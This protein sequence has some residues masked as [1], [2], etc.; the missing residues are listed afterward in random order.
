MAK[1]LKLRRGTT[2]QHSSFTGAE[3]EV[4]VDTDKETLVVHNGSTAGGFALSRA[5]SPDNQKTR[6]GTGNDLEIYHDGSH[7]LVTNSTG[8]L[9]LMA[10]G[11]GVTIS[12]GDN[13]ETIAA[14]LKNG[15]VDL[16]YDNSKKFETTSTGVAISGSAKLYD[17]NK[18][19]CGHG[20]DLK[21]F[22]DG[23][24]SYIRNDTNQFYIM[25]QNNVYLQHHNAGSSIEDMLIAKGDGAVDLYYDNSKKFETHSAGCK[26]SAGNLYLDRDNAKLVLGASDD[27][28]IYH[29]GT[30]SYVRGG[31]G[32]LRIKS[33]SIKCVNDANDE[34]YISAVNGGAVELYHNNSKKFETTSSGAFCTGQL[35]V[36][37]LYMGDNDK[38]KF[39]NGDDLQIYHN[40]SHS[41][42]DNAVGSLYIRNTGTNWILLQPKTGETSVE[43]AAN[44]ATNLYYD[45]VKKLET[46]SSGVQINGDLLSNSNVKVYDNYSFLA[47][48]GNDLQIYHTGTHSYIKDAGAGNLYILTNQLEVMNAAGNAYMLR[49]IEGASIEL[50]E[51]GSKKLETVANGINVTGKIG[52]GDNTPTYEIEAKAAAPQI[53]LE[54]TSTGGSKRLDIRVNSS[55]QAYIGANQTAQSLIFQTTNNDRLEVKADGDIVQKSQAGANDTPGL[56]WNGGSSSQ[57]ANLVKLHAKQVSNWGGE[58][59]VK[60]KGANGSLSDNWQDAIRV[61]PEGSVTKPLQPSFSARHTSRHTYSHG[62]NNNSYNTEMWDV[63]SDYNTSNNRFTAPQ[64]GYYFLLHCITVR[65]GTSGILEAKIYINNSEV[66]RA[67][68]YYAG[69]STGCTV[70]CF[71]VRYLAANDY[72]TPHSH[73]SG[74][75]GA[76]QHW[77]NQAAKPIVFFQGHLCH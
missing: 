73:W 1:L 74:S 65:G 19:L 26:V 44:G 37:T 72:V 38:A 67:Y 77:E 59:M 2:S 51:N 20:D 52:I 8:Y 23:T 17:G 16:Y 45:N 58:F 53:R 28:Q 42:L 7:S 34:T 3:G 48:S 60:V 46:I 36:D 68:E 54:E 76:D 69:G 27:I 56:I 63:N 13:S 55:G 9:R 66:L 6:W 75:T 62:G 5:D 49:C 11:S 32:D 25:G 10:G 35:G 61:F 30:N 14:F 31:Q 47:G 33:N 4:T 50:Y 21:L 22:H 41:Y 70:N 71:G 40:G 12:N 24:H 18:I 39:G 57:Q 15:A 29:D 43:C 64:S